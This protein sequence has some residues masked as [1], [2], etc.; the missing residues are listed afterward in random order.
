MPKRSSLGVSA[1][2]RQRIEAIIEHLLVILDETDG[3]ENLEDDGTAEP[4]LGWTLSGLR[5]GFDD[6]E[7]DYSNAG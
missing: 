1:S 5:A 6:R 3:D 7:M 4:S 2:Q